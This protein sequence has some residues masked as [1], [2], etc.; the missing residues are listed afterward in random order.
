MPI[1]LNQNKVIILQ[2]IARLLNQSI[3]IFKTVFFI[4]FYNI[5][6]F[7]NSSVP[8]GWTLALA[9]EMSFPNNYSP[10]DSKGYSFCKVSIHL[11]S[12]QKSPR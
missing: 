4:S 7:T 10:D 12:D 2:R 5:L 3:L 1:N 9:D 11:Q 6:A 8:T